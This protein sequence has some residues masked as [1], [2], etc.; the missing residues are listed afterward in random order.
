MNNLLLFSVELYFLFFG[1]YPNKKK[2][3]LIDNSG[4]SLTLKYPLKVKLKTPA[5][6]KIIRKKSSVFMKEKNEVIIKSSLFAELELDFL[7]PNEYNSFIINSSKAR[8]TLKIYSL[9]TLND[10]FWELT[11]EGSQ[12]TEVKLP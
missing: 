1:A 4:A 9:L 7:F 2:C 12:L 10:S 11:Y 3:I 5:S 8:K 6:D